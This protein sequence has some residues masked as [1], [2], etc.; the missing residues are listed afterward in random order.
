MPPQL[1]SSMDIQGVHF[2]NRAWVAPMSQFSAR[3]YES[4]PTDWH[5]VHYGALAQGGFGLIMTEATAVCP[6]GRRTPYDVGLWTEQ[7]AE[8]WHQIT[9]FIHSQRLPA[10]S[11]AGISVKVGVQLSHAGRC[12]SSQRSF[13]GEVG[14]PLEAA[15]GGWQ[16]VGP[17]PIPYPGF[18]VPN[19][20]TVEDI[21]QVID[22][23][24]AATRR[25]SRAGFDV[26]E[27]NA[28]GGGLLHEFCS[29]LSNNRNDGYG[30][31]YTNRVRLVREIT[32]AVR[33]AW[34]GPLFVRISATDWSAGGWDGNDSVALA[35]LL[36]SEGVDLVDVSTGGNAVIEIPMQPGYQ[37]PFAERIHHFAGVRT[38]VGGLITEPRHADDIVAR[39]QADAVML[40]RV[41]LREP[42]WPQRAAHELGVPIEVAPYA[43]QHFLGAWPRAHRPANAKPA[44]RQE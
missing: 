15:E 33:R 1:F 12:A 17:S 8:R 30:G 9:D 28:G 2:A 38:A 11:G 20:M 41:A 10:Y 37:V 36:R 13:P 35:V 40:G 24:V 14:G 29:P 42:H 23:F 7:Q 43:P 4:M 39:D 31:T 22:D 25:A 32:T 19:E 21:N 44:Q 6:V 27:I 26:I 18:P 5:M 3:F 34:T 16:A